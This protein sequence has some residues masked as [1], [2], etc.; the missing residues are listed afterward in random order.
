MKDAFYT[1]EYDNT[2]EAELFENFSEHLT[3]MILYGCLVENAAV[4]LAFRMNSMDN[5][6][7]N[8]A[9]MYSKLHLLYNRTRQAGI[10]TELSEII[11]GAASVQEQT[12]A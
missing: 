5:A 11:S 3:A 12:N 10:T 1:Y 7:T 6:S 2:D 8:A 4:E 9:E